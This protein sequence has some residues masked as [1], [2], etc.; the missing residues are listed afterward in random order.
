MVRQ[1]ALLFAVLL[2][3]VFP[4]LA[5][6]SGPQQVSE[7]FSKIDR[8]YSI[9]KISYG[10]SLVLKVRAVKNASSLPV[11]YRVSTVV[12]SNTPILDSR[13]ATLT[14]LEAWRART[15]LEPALQLEL[16]SLLARPVRQKQFD[17]PGGHFRLH[18]DTSGAKSVPLV[19]SALSGVPDFVERIG[20]Y[21]DSSWRTQVENFG[22]LA[23][24]SDGSDGGDSRYD[25]YF[26]DISFFGFTQAEFIGPESWDDATSYIVCNNDFVGLSV[27]SDPEGSEIGAAKVTIAHEFQHAVQFAYD[28]GDELWFM[29]ST[30][31][32]MEEML[33]DE[34]DD[35]Y[36]YFPQFQSA[37]HTALTKT[38]AT[39]YYSTFIWPLYLSQQHDTT[40]MRQAW[41]GGRFKNAF[42]ALLDSLPVLYGISRDS[43]FS[44]FIVWTYLTGA[45]DD[46]QHFEEAPAYPEMRIFDTVTSLPVA[47]LQV[48]LKPQG[49]GSAFVRLPVSASPG[50]MKIAFNGNDGRTWSATVIATRGVS[51]HDI[52]S[53]SLDSAGF[54]IVFVPSQEQ[55]S[56]I[57][58]IGLN[59]SAYSASA[60]YLYSAEII[61]GAALSGAPVGDT[62]AYTLMD[63]H[64]GLK[65]TNH[66]TGTDSFLVF[67]HDNGGWATSVLDSRAIVLPSGS[68]T[69]AVVSVIP[70]A[71]I[72]PGMQSTVTMG[73]VSLTDG[74]V[75]DSTT[76]GQ[77]IDVFQ[78]DFN[79]DGKLN[80]V[81]I[82]T[83]IS[84]IFSGGVGPSPE[85]SAGDAT[86]DGP[87]NIVDLTYLI[88]IVFE[89]KPFP[90]CNVADSL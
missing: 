14:L 15:S 55:Y 52:F 61:S 75:A 33:F 58:L 47:N 2:W 26:D 30:A 11:E 66:G 73:A 8:D 69:T 16:Q 84:W 24:P 29:E 54:G 31:T 65:I 10:K 90:G 71:G 18:Y 50:T 83:M 23:P 35:N 40:L 80:I 68:D 19:D 82:T 6:A 17:S 56:E 25:I 81:D 64:V 87:A 36:N 51:D 22:Y 76:I 57:T 44:E 86:C 13:C 20:I 49:Y 27:N 62:I 46:G 85:T 60:E 41:E 63:N 39:H 48:K 77:T 3:N 34:V 88:S 37:P 38:I 45:R 4:R 70:P 21:A 7:V 89:G 1:I 53:I 72:L 5:L 79:W 28:F 42:D 32:W 74:S 59:L 43:A 9:G 78:G 67:A 12:D